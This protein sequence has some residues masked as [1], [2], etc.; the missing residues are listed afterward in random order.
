MGSE[1]RDTGLATKASTEATITHPLTTVLTGHTV[2]TGHITTTMTM[3]TTALLS[4]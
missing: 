2:H 1:H 3:T 4:S